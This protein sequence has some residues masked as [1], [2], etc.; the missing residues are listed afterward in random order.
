MSEYSTMAKI[1]HMRNLCSYAHIDADKKVSN[2]IDK[3]Q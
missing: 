1:F 2:S 3:M